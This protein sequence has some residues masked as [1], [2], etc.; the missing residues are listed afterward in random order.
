VSYLDVL[1]SILPMHA[2]AALLSTL[3]RGAKVVETAQK[4]S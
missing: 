4:T 1:P 3:S 2:C